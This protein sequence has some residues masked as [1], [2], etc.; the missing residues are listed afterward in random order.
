MSICE[1]LVA[2]NVE[3]KWRKKGEESLKIFV[4][5]YQEEL[6]FVVLFINFSGIFAFCLSEEAQDV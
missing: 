6:G 2:E 4:L 1:L 5:D 3:T